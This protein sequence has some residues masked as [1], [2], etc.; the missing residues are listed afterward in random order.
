MMNVIESVDYDQ[1]QAVLQDAELEINASEVHGTMCGSICNQMKTGVS[2][3][4]Q[5]LLTAGTEISGQSLAPL[6]DVLE[7]LLR[8]TADS[9]YRNVSEFSLLLP[10]DEESL[11]VRLQ[12]LAD[13][14]RGF[15]IGLLNKESF[16]IDQLGA[17]SAEMARDI[18]AVSELEPS[19]DEE[20]SEWDLAEVE[21][22]VKVGVQLIFEEIGIE[23][24]NS[25]SGEIH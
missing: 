11:S 23:K 7:S 12:A 16:S 1:L 20:D 24:E 2:P 25:V 22:Y 6:R 9:L 19:Q 18:M 13:W 3:N 14:C 15:M 8:Q 21:E 10:D 4:L 17:D 5:Q